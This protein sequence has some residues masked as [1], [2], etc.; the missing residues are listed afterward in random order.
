MKVQ[1]NKKRSFRENFKEVLYPSFSRDLANI[2]KSTGRCKQPDREI[3]E[4]R[5]FSSRFQDDCK[6]QVVNFQYKLG[7]SEHQV[8]KWEFAEAQDSKVDCRFSLSMKGFLLHPCRPLPSVLISP[9]LVLI[10]LKE[11]VNSNKTLS[12]V[13]SVHR[14]Y[15]GKFLTFTFQ[16]EDGGNRWTLGNHSVTTRWLLGEW[17]ELLTKC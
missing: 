15:V 17:F 14:R 2:N 10:L 11:L 1:N 8:W 3:Y 7:T 9:A 6:S 5:L 12:L 16:V 13:F 4:I